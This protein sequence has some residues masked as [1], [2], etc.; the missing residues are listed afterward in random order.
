MTPANFTEASDEL[1]IYRGARWAQTFT[2]T[3]KITGNPVDLT[4]YLP[5]LMSIKHADKGTLLFNVTIDST[6]AATGVLLMSLT[7]VQTGDATMTSLK[8]VRIGMRDNA[9]NPWGEGIV[10]VLPFTPTPV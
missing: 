10:E 2:Y 8:K 4:S 7:A 5:F 6:N 3:E 9:N 1:A